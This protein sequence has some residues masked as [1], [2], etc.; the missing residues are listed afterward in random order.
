M[1]TIDGFYNFGIVGSNSDDLGSLV[2]NQRE[3]SPDEYARWSGQDDES[4]N[5]LA[6]TADELVLLLQNANRIPDASIIAR[7]RWNGEGKTLT[8]CLPCL[9]HHE[10][11]CFALRDTENE[12]VCM[13]TQATA[14]GTPPIHD[15]LD[16]RDEKAR[17]LN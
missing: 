7:D 2:L 1:Y 8:L 17:F 3:K 9:R 16:R 15:S 12:C 13:C 11:Q 4:D 6:L 14:P 5:V 10:V